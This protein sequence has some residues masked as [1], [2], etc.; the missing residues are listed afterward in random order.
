MTPCAGLQRRYVPPE[1]IGC[2]PI[3]ADGPVGCPQEKG[4]FDLQG[5]VTARG[6]KGEGLLG[7]C[8]GTRVIRPL[9]EHIGQPS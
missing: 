3:V 2:P 1:Q 7:R 9:P 8:H 6:P 5:A 4:C